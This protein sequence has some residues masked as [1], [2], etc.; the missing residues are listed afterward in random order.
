MRAAAAIAIALLLCAAPAGADPA[1]IYSVGIIGGY[2][3]EAD[4]WWNAIH[5]EREV[6]KYRH[7]FGVRA[8]V[9][10]PKLYLGL[11]LAHHFGTTDTGRGTGS[12][13]EGRYHTTLFGPEIGYDARFGRYFMMRPYVGAG[14]LYEYARTTVQGVQANDDQLRFHVTPGLIVAG[15][16]GNV[17]VGVD[18]RVVVS[19][20]NAPMKWA[21]GG[22]LTLGYSF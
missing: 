15:H 6:S 22:F 18:L 1:R 7:G 14:V 11:A 10:I 12:S 8:G 19:P 13:F 9:S 20:L 3:A 16:I 21:P 17:I 2:A 5:G 4:T